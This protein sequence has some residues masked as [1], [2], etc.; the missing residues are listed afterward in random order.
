MNN[1]TLAL[2]ISEFEFAPNMVSDIVGIVASNVFLKGESYLVGPSEN[3][4]VKTRSTNYW[5]YRVHISNNS[6]WV[7]TIIDKFIMEVLDVKKD[8]WSKIKDDID[9]ELYIGIGFHSDD[10]L[11]NYHFDRKVI[12]LLS[13][14]K[15][16]IDIDQHVVSQSRDCQ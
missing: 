13:D 2:K 7:K 16:E 14:L 15:V 5:E 4:I 1:I 6:I 8:L 9:M 12:N 10:E 11:D 3:S